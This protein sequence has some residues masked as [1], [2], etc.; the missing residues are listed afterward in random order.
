MINLIFRIFNA[1][2]RRK[3][4]AEVDRGENTGTNGEVTVD[5]DSLKVSPEAPDVRD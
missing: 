2:F 3:S 5:I 1:I 4:M